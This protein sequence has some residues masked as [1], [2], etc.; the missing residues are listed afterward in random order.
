MLEWV[1]RKAA[2][3]VKGLEHKCHEQQLRELGVCR[4]KQK[5]FRRD[6]VTLYSYLRGV[7]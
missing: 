7:L 1:Q 5:R 3:L 2:E 4:L 6:P